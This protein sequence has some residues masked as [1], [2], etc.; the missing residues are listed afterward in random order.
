LTT[1]FVVAKY[2]I[3]PAATGPRF[4]AFSTAVFRIF[5]CRLFTLG[6]YACPAS[7]IV[8]P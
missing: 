2:L 6:T 3:R 4:P 7:R 1:L 8:R 5:R